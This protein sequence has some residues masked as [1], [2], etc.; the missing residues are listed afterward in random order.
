MARRDR[1]CCPVGGV[2][3]HTRLAVAPRRQHRMW[4]AI[5]STI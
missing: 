1:A 3:D 2:D 4:A 5:Q